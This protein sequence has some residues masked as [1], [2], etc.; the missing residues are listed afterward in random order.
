MEERVKKPIKNADV[1]YGQPLMN[2]NL[3]NL[4]EVRS[5]LEDIFS[6]RNFSKYLHKRKRFY[7]KI[8]KYNLIFQSYD[9]YILKKFKD[10]QEGY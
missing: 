3:N 5:S 2:L 7:I 9:F 8:L 6:A 1:F 10:F 4:W